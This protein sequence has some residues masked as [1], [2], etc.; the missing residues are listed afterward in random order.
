[1]TGFPTK[2]SWLLFNGKQLISEKQISSY[3]ASKK[4]PLELVLRKDA[5][6]IQA[7]LLRGVEIAL[8]AQRFDSIEKVSLVVE[9]R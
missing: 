2:S 9:E 7:N 1:M 8:F 3:P 6:R 5:L 4:T